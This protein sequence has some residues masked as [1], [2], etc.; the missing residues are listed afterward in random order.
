V[1]DFQKALDVVLDHEGWGSYTTHPL[2]KGGPTRWGITL[3]TLADWRGQPVD[4]SDVEALTEEEASAIYRARYWAP[5]RGDQISHQGVATKCFD[6]SVNM[7]VGTASRLVQLAC[8]WCGRSVYLDGVFGPVTLGAVN[9]C[10]P[11]EFLHQLSN[12]MQMHYRGIV[13][14]DPSQR[15]FLRGWLARASWGDDAG[16]GVA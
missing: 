2:D 16:Q 11:G 15:V 10:E 1:G 9:A 13:A 6:A 7:G 8:R 3:A 5:M 12:A 4:P 14:R